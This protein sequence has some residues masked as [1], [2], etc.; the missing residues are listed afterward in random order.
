[1]VDGSGTGTLGG[2]FGPIGP[3]GWIGSSSPVGECPRPLSPGRS[4]G[5]SPGRLGPS[6]LPRPSASRDGL[7]NSVRP[8]GEVASG[9]KPAPP[10][11]PA[12]PALPAPPVLPLPPARVKKGPNGIC[13]ACGAV[14]SRHPGHVNATPRS[15]STS[16][17]Y[18]SCT[19]SLDQAS[20]S[21]AADLLD[22]E[23]AV[24]DDDSLDDPEDRR[25]SEL[26]TACGSAIGFDV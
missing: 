17:P 26:M 8:S 4:L 11:F 23:L 16:S 1:M 21:A 20:G 18:V 13:G 24:P 19:A 14:Q 25:P 6:P 22:P 10:A 9:R 3:I 12:P 15:A 2:T 5:K 7:P